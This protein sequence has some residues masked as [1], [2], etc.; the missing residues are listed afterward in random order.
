MKPLILSGL[1]ACLAT[2]G[3]ADFRICNET[4]RKTFASIGYKEGDAWVSEG[5]WTI[6]PG[7]C[8]IPIVGDL[9]NRYYYIRAESETGNWTGDYSFCYINDAFT[10]RG[11]ENCTVRGYKTGGFFE[12]D[13]GN[14]LDWTQNLSD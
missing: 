4:G 9:K 13:T 5:W 6:Q 7:E 3:L 10:I 14:A 12:I 11:D 1:L 2:P 8:S